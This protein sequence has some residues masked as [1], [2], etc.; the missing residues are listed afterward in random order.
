MLL[1]VFSTLEVNTFLGIY[2][3]GLRAGGVSILW[4]VFALAL[5]LAGIWNDYRARRSRGA[6]FRGGGMES[7]VFDL[8][9]LDPLYRIIAFV[10][11]G[12]LVLSGSF[13]YLNTARPGGGEEE[14]DKS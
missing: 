8:A 11:L 10:L 5:I 6:R 12:A 14:V 3:E 13:V 9:Q 7:A 1:F 2:V 4:S